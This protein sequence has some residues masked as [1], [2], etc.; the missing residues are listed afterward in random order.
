MIHHGGIKMITLQKVEEIE[1]YQV[2]LSLKRKTKESPFISI[3]IFAKEMR[4]ICAETL[5]KYL[6]PTFPIKACENL[7]ER[8]K[9]QGYLEHDEERGTY[10]LTEFG[11]KAC[12]DKSFW[13]GERGTYNVYICNSSLIEEKRIQIEMVDKTDTGIVKDTPAEISDYPKEEELFMNNET[14]LLEEIGDKCL[15]LKPVNRLL[16]IRAEANEATLTISNNEKVLFE[17]KLKITEFDVQDKILAN[18][19]E[20]EYDLEKKAILVDFDKHILSF[21][22]STIIS[23]PSFGENQFKEIKLEN[24]SYI[25]IN[26]E[27][28]KLWFSELLYKNM[29]NYFIDDKS[30]NDFVKKYAKLFLAH[31]PSLP[32]PNRKQLIESFSIRNDAFYQIAKLETIDYLRY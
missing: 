28:A 13:I 19:T 29:V 15:Q 16:E 1:V 8:L 11:E 32:V 27:I 12:I 31:Y 24:I 6:F 4:E 10:C 25:P 3:L 18:C 22:R 17:K 7:L 23:E 21:S 2:K 14:Y 30:F 5:K 9:N 26:E 20:Y